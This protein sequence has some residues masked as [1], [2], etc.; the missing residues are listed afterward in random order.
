MN[1]THLL[2]GEFFYKFFKNLYNFIY[3]LCQGLCKR[4]KIHVIFKKNE[5]YLF[6]N[7]FSAKQ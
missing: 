6:I 5:I 2:L 4:I 7:H 1:H 3:L